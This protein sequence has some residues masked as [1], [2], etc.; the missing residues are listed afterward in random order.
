M[1]TLGWLLKPGAVRRL[2]KLVG[3]APTELA[4]T[5]WSELADGPGSGLDADTL[6][7]QHAAAFL[8]ANATAV[9]AA[10]LATP[11]TIF[12]SGDAAG[13]VAFDGSANITLAVAVLDD[14][15]NHIIGNVDGLQ[16][17]LDAV[18]PDARLSGDYH[19]A[20]LILDDTHN[21]I[22]KAST[23][24]YMN[25]TVYAP[26]VAVYS[27][28][29]DP[30]AGNGMIDTAAVV[31]KLPVLSDIAKTHLR[32]TIKGYFEDLPI[33]FM[34]AATWGGSSW[35]TTNARAI[36]LGSKNIPIRL[37]TK[38]GDP[39][40]YIG[41]TSLAGVNFNY[42]V[43]DV[44]LS[45]NDIS[46][47]LLKGWTVERSA[48][49]GNYALS[50]DLTRAAIETN[51]I[52]FA[53]D[54]GDKL[55]LWGDAYGFGVEGGAQYAYA[56]N[57]HRWYLNGPAD[58]GASDWMEL[59][60]TGLNLAQGAVL[61]FANNTQQKI[62]LYSDTFAIGVEASTQY[63]RAS[64]YH[65]W[66]LNTPADGGA[67]DYMQLST[68]GL[69]VLGSIGTQTNLTVSGFSLLG[70]SSP[71]IKCKIVSGVFPSTTGGSV[72]WA[73]GLDY[74]KILGATIM[75]GRSDG[76]YQISGFGWSSGEFMRAFL[77]PTAVYI[78]GRSGYDSVF[79]GQAVRVLIWY[80]A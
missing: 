46:Q 32:C 2:L 20:S 37:G 26:V 34:L 69:D 49:E 17:A 9:S 41:D 13:S 59:N 68:A 14:S 74:Q 29:G 77:T 16:T 58:E 78:L 19:N 53:A 7:G 33:E 3:G 52:Q 80:T 24:S 10:K 8:G 72:Q 63:Y 45:G 79:L 61:Q 25:A 11:R 30:V 75:V 64:L 50:A 42:V 43:S 5:D 71:W 38:S 39:I 65:R 6:D 18:V 22:K 15:H 12:L 48:S 60:A 56:H 28:C 44:F 36:S 55:K 47:A 4:D 66:Y 23:G 40:I 57:S 62:N 1:A 35:S 54:E 73:H 31:I 51:K 21:V 67:S 70:E 76:I 27:F